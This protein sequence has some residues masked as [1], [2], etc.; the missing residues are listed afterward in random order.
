MTDDLSERAGFSYDRIPARMERPA[1]KYVEE[2]VIPGD[3]LQAVLAD[4]LTR[5]YGRADMGNQARLQDWVHWLY[6]DIPSTCWGSE[7]AIEEW[8]EKGGLRGMMNGAVER[9]P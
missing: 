1:R 7:E 5:T 6:N 3:F 4:S 8:H 9:G 2:G